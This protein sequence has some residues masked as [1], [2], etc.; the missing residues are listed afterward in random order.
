MVTSST[1]QHIIVLNIKLLFLI[2]VSWQSLQKDPK[3]AI[4]LLTWIVC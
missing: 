2:P 4:T 1:S 3:R